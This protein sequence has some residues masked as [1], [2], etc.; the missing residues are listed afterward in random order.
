MIIAITL[1]LIGLCVT[2]YNK[3]CVMLDYWEKPNLYHSPALF[4]L[5]FIT[6]LA[7]YFASYFLIYRVFGLYIAFG[8]IAVQFIL[9]SILLRIFFRKRVAVWYPHCDKAVRNGQREGETP[10][11]DADIKGRALMLAENAARKAMKDEI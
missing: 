3:Y 9:G 11:S 2:C 10:M 1:Y 4:S 5:F 6:K 8:A 7:L